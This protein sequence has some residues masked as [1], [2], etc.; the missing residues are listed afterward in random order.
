MIV[1]ATWMRYSWNTKYHHQLRSLELTA[2]RGPYATPEGIRLHVP[3]VLAAVVQ[4]HRGRENKLTCDDDKRFNAA[5][6]TANGAAFRGLSLSESR[7]WFEV[8]GRRRGEAAL[9][10]ARGGAAGS[11]N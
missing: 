3:S 6:T 9:I 5:Q 11:E 2:L 10:D 7:H 4:P 8:F 1:T